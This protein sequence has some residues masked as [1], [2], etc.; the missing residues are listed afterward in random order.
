MADFNLLDKL[1]TKNKTSSYHLSI[2]VDLE[3]FSFCVLDIEKDLY[4]ALKKY[5]FDKIKDLENLVDRVDFLFKND[6]IL[7]N[8][9]QSISFVYLSQK[10]TLVPDAFFDKENLK[11]YFEFNHSLDELDEIHFNHIPAIQA[12]NVFA[13][14][15]YLANQVYNEYN[16]VKFFH[17]ATPFINSVIKGFSQSSGI[18]IN[19]N[20]NFFDIVVKQNNKLKLYNTFLYKNETDLLYFLFYVIKQLNLD[21]DTILLTLC[22]EQSNKFIFFEAIKK[23]VPGIMFF[24]PVSPGF[25]SVFEKISVHK[26]FNLFYLYN[27]E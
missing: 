15:N 6:D 5:P 18:H 12:Y 7:K 4:I 11:S 20:N 25:S 24:E 26:F 13:I 17:Q 10:S 9:Y 23:Y 19:L 1:F 2:Q 8:P 14:P 3:G 27:C 21:L 16:R 22:G